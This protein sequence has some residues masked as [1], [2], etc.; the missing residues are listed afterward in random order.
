M[1]TPTM[2]ASTAVVAPLA[3]ELA[4]VRA[5][6]GAHRLA[7]LRNGRQGWTA[8]FGRLAG[9]DVVLMATGD[10]PAAAAAGLEA[11]LAAVRPR[12]LLVVGVAGGLTPGLAE[13][14]LVAARRVVDAALG[15]AAQDPDAPWLDAAL[16]AGAVAG[17]VVSADHILASPAARQT[18]LRQ[19]LA[20][21]EQAA[22]TVDLESAAYAR[23]AAA[24]SLPYLVVRA[25]LD[26]AEEELPLDFEA[27]RDR[28]GRVSNAR[29]VLRALSRP[30]TLG[31]LWRLRTR[32]RAA[33]ARL[34]ALAR[35]LVAATPASGGRGEARGMANVT[36]MTVTT[37]AAAQRGDNPAAVA[38]RRTA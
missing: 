32:L 30:R 7:R 21:D 11:L 3:A 27:C 19:A 5:A 25:V 33:A 29:V 38:G 34:G 13:G 24:W 37:E 31:Q 35:R 28:S 6:T 1:P 15:R 14:T 8:T 4:G 23:V 17:I 18:V 10:G 12:R 22:A 26:P 36:E 16:A 9:E 2:S 20:A